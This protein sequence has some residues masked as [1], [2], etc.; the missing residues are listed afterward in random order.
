M[1]EWK[2]CK[3]GEVVKFG[4]GKLRPKTSGD[5]PVYGSMYIENVSFKKYN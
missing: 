3:L 5:T 4:N 2:K 1:S